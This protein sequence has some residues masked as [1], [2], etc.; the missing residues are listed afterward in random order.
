MTKTQHICDQCEKDVNGSGYMVGVDYK[1]AADGLLEI[2]IVTNFTL[3]D[4][5]ASVAE[6]HYCGR[7][8]LMLALNKIVDSI[9]K[10]GSAVDAAAAPEG[11]PLHG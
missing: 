2:Q 7:N 4:F 3:G 8:C 1:N 9:A 10:Q 5:P 11:E 6:S